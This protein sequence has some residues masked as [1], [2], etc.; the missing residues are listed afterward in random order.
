MT[1]GTIQPLIHDRTLE[2]VARNVLQRA[3]P[4]KLSQTIGEVGF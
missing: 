3:A 1:V 2:V 4:S